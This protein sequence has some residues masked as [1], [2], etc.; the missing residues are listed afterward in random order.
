MGARRHECARAPGTADRARYAGEAFTEIIL[1]ELPE[2]EGDSDLLFHVWN[3]YFANALTYTDRTPEPRIEIGGHAEPQQR[4][5]YVRD[6]GAG[7]DMRYAAKL[8]GMFQRLHSQEEFPGLGTSLAIARRIMNRH[9]G[10]TWAEGSAQ[11]GACFYFALPGP[12]V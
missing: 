2:G 11:Q 9:G 4:I 12:T 8:F 3:T 1:H 6:N 10:R 5:W 7:F